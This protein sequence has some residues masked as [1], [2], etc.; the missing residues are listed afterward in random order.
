[1]NIRQTLRRPAVL[2]TLLV[3]SLACN[4]FLAGTMVGRL[5]ARAMHQ[6]S[7][8]RDVDDRLRFMPDQ[9][10]SELRRHLLPPRTEMR[11]HYRE[12]RALQQELAA[13]LAHEPPRREVLERELARLRDLNTAMQQ[14]LHE[15]FVDTVLE[16][17]PGERGA[18]MDA[19]LAPPR[20]PVGP[21]RAAGKHHPGPMQGKAP[22]AA[23]ATLP[24]AGNRHESSGGEQPVD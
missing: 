14:R 18:M 22:L 3:V 13:E 2:A 7:F 9:R 12:V 15:R 1:M 5:G 10:R 6:P 4:L 19:L 23:T 24:P 16:L 21:R 8:A 11:R 20:S 17:P